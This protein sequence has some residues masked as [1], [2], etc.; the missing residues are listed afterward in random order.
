M[1]YIVRANKDKEV[2]GDNESYENFHPSF[3]YPVGILL[4]LTALAPIH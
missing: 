1:R 2:L 3:S 4:F